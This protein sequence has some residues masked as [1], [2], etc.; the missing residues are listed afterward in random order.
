MPAWS[1]PAPVGV[2]RCAGR[3]IHEIH[4]RCR[5][6]VRTSEAVIRT[7]RRTGARNAS[8]ASP[9]KAVWT[10]ER[11]DATSLNPLQAVAPSA[12]LRPTHP[13][14]RLRFGE[15]V[16]NLFGEGE[17]T[18]WFHPLCAAY[19]RPEPV[20]EALAGASGSVPDRE[21]LER[22]AVGSAA[23]KH[24]SGS[25]CERSPSGKANCRSWATS[26]SR[27][28]VGVSASYSTKK[29]VLHPE[30]ACTSLVAGP[31]SRPTRS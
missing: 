3:E 29:V 20:L 31:T 25:T 13:A 22:T 2:W 17:T 21:G 12:A 6:A 24:S 26:Q 9:A 10:S 23:N 15:R 18:L 27:W 5:R 28:E 14:R 11:P 30:D 8:G 7:D 1:R 16:P 19:K 4:C